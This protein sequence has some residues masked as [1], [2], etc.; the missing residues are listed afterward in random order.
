MSS[1]IW[2]GLDLGTTH[3]SIAVWDGTRG[4]AKWI[5]V[6][7]KLAKEENSGKVGRLVP[8]QA[9][10][11]E[12]SVV[13]EGLY[14]EQELT[15]KL[16]VILGAEASRILHGSWSSTTAETFSGEQITAALIT[17]LKRQFASVTDRSQE[18]SFDVSSISV[19]PLPVKPTKCTGSS[20]QI[21]P[22]PLVVTLLTAL[23]QAAI[24]Y[25]R[26]NVSRK[27]LQVPG[28]DPH[29]LHVV[30]GV[31]ATYSSHQRATLQ[32]L[33]QKAGFLSATCLTESTAAAL[34]YGM[35]LSEVNKSV[36]TIVVV[37]MG[38]GTTDVTF[39]AQEGDADWNVLT[40]FGDAQLG[41]MD[42]DQALAKHVMEK[43]KGHGLH[44]RSLQLQCQIV[45]EQLCQLAYEAPEKA[46]EEIVVAM[47]ILQQK[48][49]IHV[50]LSDLNTAIA[51][52]LDRTRV[53]LHSALEEWKKKTVNDSTDRLL[54]EVILMGGA[55]RVPAIRLIVREVTENWRRQKELCTTV[56]PLSAIA[57]GCAIHAARLSRHVPI[58][59]LRS[60]LMLD[61]CPYAMGVLL[62]EGSRRFVEI[63]PRESALP[64]TGT[65]EFQLARVDQPGITLQAVE[66][67]KQSDSNDVQTTHYVPIGDFTFLLHRPESLASIQKRTVDIQMTLQP[68]GAFVVSIFDPLD[69]EHLRKRRHEEELKKATEARDDDATV[70][71]QEMLLI[72][73]I[74]IAVAI[75]TAVKLVFGAAL[76]EA[77]IDADHVEL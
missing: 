8:S 43:V 3:C 2:I 49:T 42:M 14:C 39:A 70:S 48:L 67:V 74:V 68:N 64:A 1:A 47:K 32:S 72:A 34:T 71:H 41:G 35:G 6:G 63:I 73:A 13:D 18:K 37:D 27:H 45:K 23:R 26:Q 50:S 36:T 25:L 77:S 28:S 61:T 62:D 65:A 20:I 53:V 59:E 22:F 15:D 40:T 46:P 21:S 38:G 7:G 44:M 19:S 9:L 33:A 76:L 31:P 52:L 12:G 69:P 51:P 66:K 4:H 10:V 54:D 5:R 55:T 75:Y 56:H 60:A 29:Q 58:H 24:Q 16:H 57:Q 30:L 17:S 11:R